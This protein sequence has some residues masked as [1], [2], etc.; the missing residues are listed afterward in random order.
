MLS[1]RHAEVAILRGFITELADGMI[2]G[3]TGDGIRAL[4]AEV[5]LEAD[6]AETLAGVER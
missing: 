2:P 4:A 1:Q 5:L 6:A 3:H